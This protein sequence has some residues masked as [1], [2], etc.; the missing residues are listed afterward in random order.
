RW[1][2]AALVTAGEPAKRDETPRD[3][4]DDTP[5]LPTLEDFDAAGA[6]RRLHGHREQF[7]RLLRAF[8]TQQRDATA[9]I[10]AALVEADI[11]QARHTLHTLKG[12]AA[13]LG[14]NSV[15]KAAR[16]LE[17]RLV[18]GA[19]LSALAG[20]LATVTA[21]IDA[22][23]LTQANPG[24]S[25]LT[26]DPAAMSQL[27]TELRRYVNEQELIPDALLDELKC[28]AAGDPSGG[29]LATLLQHIFDFDNAGALADIDAIQG[30]IAVTES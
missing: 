26:F 3:A 13:T 23:P 9:Q 29:R 19:E 21:A 28:A 7:V 27:L 25:L 5:L 30:G 4:P 8:A 11:A 20:C 2:P 6:L 24:K 10:E 17:G 1:L 12:I 18:L 15:A 22:M 16:V 14:L